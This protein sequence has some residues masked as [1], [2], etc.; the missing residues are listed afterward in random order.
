[1]VEIA[2]VRRVP[3]TIVSFWKRIL[4]EDASSRHFMHH[5]SSLLKAWCE[6]I[7]CLPFPYPEQGERPAEVV[8][9]LHYR[10]CG[11]LHA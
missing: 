7:C 2:V 3:R 6:P 9:R 5:T 11:V 4:H 1:M 8:E 10:L